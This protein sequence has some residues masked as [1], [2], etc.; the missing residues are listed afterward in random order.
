[1]KDV[2]H[3]IID[4][5]S[6]HSDVTE[7]FN[8]VN[9]FLV[10]QIIEFSSLPQDKSYFINIIEDLDDK[11]KVEVDEVELSMQNTLQQIDFMEA[12]IK[13]V[14]TYNLCL[15]TQ[16]NIIKEKN[17][18]EFF[19][20]VVKKF[21]LKDIRK[22][23]NKI[24]FN[25]IT[26]DEKYSLKLKTNWSAFLKDKHYSEKKSLVLPDLIPKSIQEKFSS[27]IFEAFIDLIAEKRI[28][29][30]YLVSLTDNK[31]LNFSNEKLP[32]SSDNSNLYSIIKY[33]FDDE[34]RYDDKLKIFRTILS[35][36][37]SDTEI[38][39]I[40]WNRAL[41][42]LKSNYSLFINEKMEDFISLKTSLT[43][44][45]S[46]LNQVVDKSIDN[47]VDEFS[48]QILIIIAT[49]LSSFVVKIGSNNQFILIISAIVYVVLILI[50]N[51]TKG[52]HFSSISFKKSIDDIRDI[53]E[54]LKELEYSSGNDVFNNNSNDI[55]SSL[56]KLYLIENM[57][58]ALLALIAFGLIAMLVIA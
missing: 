12:D 41:Q 21:K 8:L 32:D 37:L 47:K 18:N 24:L 35:K 54:S 6:K 40:N 10:K 20:S 39:N 7:R 15:V 52:V 14:I 34:Y 19:R 28:G 38:R 29:D 33:I 56:K 17:I 42:T 11:I 23:N 13:I 58:F 45:V 43:K 25:L 46:M 22:I 50:F 49:V 57:Q 4:F 51:F 9:N 44:Q 26:N 3:N 5:S 30:D 27:D 53:G 55:K 31:T 1:M 16:I 36:I 2:Y 48:K